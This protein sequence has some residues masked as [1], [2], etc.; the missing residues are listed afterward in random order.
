VYLKY[1][2]QF[3]DSDQIDEVDEASLPGYR[4]R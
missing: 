2:K 1:A 3:L 4:T